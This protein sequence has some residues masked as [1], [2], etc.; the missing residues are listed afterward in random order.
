[1][2][3]KIRYYVIETIGPTI[4]RAPTPVPV[5]NNCADDLVPNVEVEAWDEYDL[6]NWNALVRK[7]KEGRSPFGE[8]KYSQLAEKIAK[9]LK[10]SKFQRVKKKD[11]FE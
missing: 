2:V 10:E 8:S 6:S 3:N 5:P 4:P 7:K 1:M 9:N 11:I